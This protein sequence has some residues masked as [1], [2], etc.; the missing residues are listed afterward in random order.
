MHKQTEG[1]S[2]LDFLVGVSLTLMSSVT[3]GHEIM[4]QVP[5][6]VAPSPYMVISIHVTAQLLLVRL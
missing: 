5:A 4:P 3:V 2:V 1:E 6:S